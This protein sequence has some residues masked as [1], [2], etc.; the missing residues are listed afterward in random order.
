V[1]FDEVVTIR[2]LL[3][4]THPKDVTKLMNSDTNRLTTPPQV[5]FMCYSE[6]L[7]KMRW[8]LSHPVRVATRITGL[9]VDRRFNGE[10]ALAATLCDLFQSH[11]AW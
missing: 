6:G 8:H 1:D 10:F 9:Y 2:T 5:E 7:P 3:F 4:V 11:A